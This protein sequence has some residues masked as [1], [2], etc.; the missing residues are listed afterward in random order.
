MLVNARTRAVVARDVE[1]AETRR[2]R[3]RG[4]LGRDGLAPSSALVIAPCCA[5]HT[6]FMRFAIDVIF[7]ARDGRVLRIVR[8]LPPWRLAV[9]PR[10]HRVVELP[11]GSLGQDILAIGD[12]LLIERPAA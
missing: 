10:A 2:A 7:V 11:A 5:I 1:L 12:Q 8:D 4:L 6:A 3:R 9:A